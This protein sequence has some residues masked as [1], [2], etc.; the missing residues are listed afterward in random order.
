MNEGY[1]SR[2]FALA[3][4]VVFS[5]QMFLIWGY[6][7]ADVYQETVLWALGLYFGANVTTRIGSAK[8]G[9]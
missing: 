5:S 8:Y 4:W 7:D 1:G 3:C 6:L 9:Q 2:K